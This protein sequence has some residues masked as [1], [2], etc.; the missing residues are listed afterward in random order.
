MATE[1]AHLAGVYQ[2]FPVAI[3]KGRGATVWDA[4]GKE[5]NIARRRAA[6]IITIKPNV[7]ILRML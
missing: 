5:M 2:K 1:N 6:G 7:K 4:N 3:V